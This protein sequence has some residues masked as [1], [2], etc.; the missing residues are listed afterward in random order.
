MNEAIT[1]L[2]APQFISKIAKALAE[3]KINSLLHYFKKEVSSATLKG[4][5]EQGRQQK[6]ETA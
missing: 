5:E 3:A 4:M 1:K 2:K 6:L